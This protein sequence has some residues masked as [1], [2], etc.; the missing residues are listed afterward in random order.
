MLVVGE[1]D[2]GGV[3]GRGGELDVDRPFGSAGH[4]VLVD[5][6]AVVLARADDA[7]G[8]V[9]GAQEVEEVAPAEAA[10]VIEDAVGDGDLV[11]GR[12]AADQ[13]RPGRALD[14]DVQLGFGDRHAAA[15]RCS[16]GSC[17]ETTL[18]TST[19]Y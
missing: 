7:R 11:A 6:V 15:G 18:S 3:V 17:V 9:V 1:A 4:E 12:D 14:V 5:D 16:N 8:G 19:T 13:V 10:V 2:P